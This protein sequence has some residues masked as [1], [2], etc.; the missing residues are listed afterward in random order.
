MN[1]VKLVAIDIG[2]TLITDDNKITQE[3]IETLKKIKSLGIKIALVTAR[4]YSSTK[5]ISNLIDADFGVFGNGSIVM[6]LKNFNTYYSEIIPNQ[7]VKDL[8]SFGKKNDMYI[9]LSQFLYEASDENKYFVKKHNILNQDYP[10]EFKSNIRKVD[11][12][13]KYVKAVN[14][15]VNVIFVTEKNMD[16]F[17]EKIKLNF[18][19]L[20][21]TEYNKNLYETAINQTI[22]YVEI[23]I[24]NTTKLDGLKKLIKKLNIQPEEVIVIGDGNNDVQMFNYF[25]NSGCLLN[26]SDQ[27]KKAVNYVSKKT[28]NDSGVS[29]IIKYYVKGLMK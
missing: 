16:E 9:H 15:V 18:Q 2:G 28:N 4:M 7:L 13:N 19:N 10:E 14:D 1:N 25:K 5:Y 12:L 26:G 22:N 3:N 27:A 21:I 23:G 6:N 24:K 17:V 20:F 29:E 8:V 11:D